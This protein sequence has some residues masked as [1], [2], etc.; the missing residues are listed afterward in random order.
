[1]LSVLSPDLDHL[2]TSLQKDFQF[3]GPY[4]RN[5]IQPAV[6]LKHRAVPPKD[7]PRH[8]LSQNSRRSTTQYARHAISQV[9]AA[10]LIC[11]RLVRFWGKGSDDLFSS[12]F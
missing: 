9:S 4:P 6:A 3:L 8:F 1:M 7:V 5:G 12:L 10:W 2:C 11:G